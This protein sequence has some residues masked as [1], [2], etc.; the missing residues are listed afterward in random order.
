MIHDFSMTRDNNG[1]CRGREGDM[2]GNFEVGA[3]RGEG[4]REGGSGKALS[5]HCLG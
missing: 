1:V 3:V 4:E 5:I 2:D